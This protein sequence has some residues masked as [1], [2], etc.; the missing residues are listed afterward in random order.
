MKFKHVVYALIILVVGFLVYRRISA[1]AGNATAGGQGAG[2]QTMSVN[3]Y[4]VKPGSISDKII[5]TGSIQANEEVNIRPEAAGIITGIHFQ[6]GKPVSKGALLLKINDSELQAQLSKALT[7]QKLAAEKEYRQRQLLEK[8]GVS[9]QDYDAILAE[10][11]SLKAETRLIEAQIEQTE[12]RAPFSGKIGL[13]EVSLG[14][15]VDPSTVI[16]SLVDNNPAKI[17]FSAPE[18]Y[19]N[20]IPD[21]ATINF[22]VKGIDKKF[23][24]NVYARGANINVG[25]RTLEL[26]AMV[27]NDDNLLIPGSFAEVELVL[28]Q[29]N[30][31]LLVPT[32]SIIPVMNGQK[33]YVTR[34][35]KAEEVMVE[36]GIRNDSMVH[37]TS[38]LKAGDTIIT[39]GIMT[40]TP[41]VPVQLKT[42]Q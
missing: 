24:A 38:G 26:K 5:I 33:A 36:T 1:S 31:A 28:T 41:G 20:N 15:Y 8:G 13:R 14:D 42:I 32:E 10:L 27:P 30:N 7:M 17:V 12:I 9:K 18:Q 29:T 25:T 34:N 16:T 6:E 2:M 40:L 35:G 22:T 19:A 3:A 23:T 4:V 11:N 37:I 39:T 21:N